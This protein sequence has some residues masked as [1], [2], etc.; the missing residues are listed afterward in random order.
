MSLKQIV[1]FNLHL[2]GPCT[3]F[4]SGPVKKI[5]DFEDLKHYVATYSSSMPYT[6]DII[7]MVYNV[8]TDR[9]VGGGR[10][11]LGLRRAWNNYLVV[12]EEEINKFKFFVGNK[13]IYPVDIINFLTEQSGSPLDFD[14][15]AE[16]K[17]VMLD[18]VHEQIIVGTRDKKTGALLPDKKVRS[19]KWHYLTNQEIF[20]DRNINQ[21]WPRDTG[22]IP[23][24]FNS[25][26]V[27]MQ[28]ER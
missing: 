6:I 11:T 19:V 17:P 2:T 21:L 25:L 20:V 27:L 10:N 22:E 23:W 8:D 5:A 16:N 15:K 7:E 13:L 28:N 12:D 24:N 1:E 14:V 18:G 3:P 26:K 4:R 9:Y